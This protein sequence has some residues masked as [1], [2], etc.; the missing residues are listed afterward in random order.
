M[1]KAYI[2]SL[3]SSFLFL[4]I[5]NACL[6]FSGTLTGKHSPLLRAKLVDN[7]VEK[8]SIKLRTNFGPKVRFRLASSSRLGT[9][10]VDGAVNIARSMAD[11]FNSSSSTAFPDTKPGQRPK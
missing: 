10:N 3:I 4:Q 9:L 11:L 1:K 5:S 2:L 8:C 6:L 7:G